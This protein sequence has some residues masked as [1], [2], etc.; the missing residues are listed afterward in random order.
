MNPSTFGLFKL[1]YFPYNTEKENLEDTYIYNVRV[2]KK[3]GDIYLMT[4]PEVVCALSD[5]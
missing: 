5:P 1:V 2:K 4:W 3:Y